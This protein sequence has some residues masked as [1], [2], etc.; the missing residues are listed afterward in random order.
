MITSSFRVD[1]YASHSTISTW[2]LVCS[3]TT[4]IQGGGNLLKF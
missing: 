1:T 3:R 2:R 4:Y